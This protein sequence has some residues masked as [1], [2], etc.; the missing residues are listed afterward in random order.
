MKT[1]CTQPFCRLRFKMEHK[2]DGSSP[3]GGT[4]RLRTGAGWF[5]ED[6]KPISRD[7]A[8]RPAK[9]ATPVAAAA[10]RMF[11]FNPR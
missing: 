11:L 10:G 4:G 1:D 5:A 9:A 7:S 6:R 2:V 8:D 3:A